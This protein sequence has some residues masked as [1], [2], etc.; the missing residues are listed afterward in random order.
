VKMQNKWQVIES[1]IRQFLVPTIVELGFQVTDTNVT[2]REVTLRFEKSDGS[3]SGFIT[4]DCRDW[5]LKED[6]FKNCMLFRFKIF[7]NRIQAHLREFVA[8]ETIDAIRKQGWIFASVDELDDLL[9]DVSKL[10]KSELPTWFANP[11]RLAPITQYVPEKR[12]LS[13]KNTLISVEHELTTA[14]D[15]NDADEIHRLE[16][17]INELN[18]LIQKTEREIE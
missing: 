1:K 3:D 5:T 2:G 4:I 12:L 18:L 10:A 11:T 15:N 14:Q 7:A 6:P 9:K 8:T 17:R 13:L 16:E